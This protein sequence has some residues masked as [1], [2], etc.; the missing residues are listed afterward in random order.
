MIMNK[1]LL[2]TL[3]LVVMAYGCTQVTDFESCVK[4]GNPVMESYP[5][6]CK[7]GDTLYI[8]DEVLNV[9]YYESTEQSPLTLVFLDLKNPLFNS[10]DIPLGILGDKRSEYTVGSTVTIP[11][12]VKLYN[13]EDVTVTLLEEWYI[14][15]AATILEKP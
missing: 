6:Q 7:H 8:E 3:V 14:F 9:S 11:V 5:R 10:S 4:A 1:M 15:Y 13:I 12:H 2:L